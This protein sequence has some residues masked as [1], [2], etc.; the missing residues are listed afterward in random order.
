M[1]KTSYTIHHNHTFDY[2]PPFDGGRQAA[3]S[4]RC[5][6]H[7]MQ[8]QAQGSGVLSGRMMA[9]KMREERAL[10]LQRGRDEAGS[11][12]GMPVSEDAISLVVVAGYSLGHPGGEDAVTVVQHHIAPGYA[13]RRQVSHVQ[14]ADTLVGCKRRG[15]PIA[16]DGNVGASVPRVPETSNV[17]QV[18]QPSHVNRGSCCSRTEGQ[19][20]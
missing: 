6:H 8:E 19:H 4:N 15:V 13:V 9:G 12:R 10:Q 5:R 2:D 14:G 11:T 16:V 7:I 1:S 3:S 17:T 18:V 20:I